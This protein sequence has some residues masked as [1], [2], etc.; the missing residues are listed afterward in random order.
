MCGVWY[1]VHWNQKEKGNRV[2]DSLLSQM[3]SSQMFWIG[4]ERED[5]E[6]N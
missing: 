3:V 6:T 5:N 2:Q 1:K 4:D